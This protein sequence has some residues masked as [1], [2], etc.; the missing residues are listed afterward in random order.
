MSVNS[1]GNYYTGTGGTGTLMHAGESITTTQTLYIY[2]I[3][4]TTPAC[5]VENYFTV[6]FTPRVD[7][8]NPVIACENYVLP[9]LTNGDYYTQPGGTGTMLHAG[10]IISTN[11][12]IYIY[13]KSINRNGDCFDESN[14]TVT[15]VNKPVLVTIPSNAITIC[16]LD[17]NND[18]FTNFDLTTLSPG[19][20]AGQS[21]S[22]YQVTYYGSLN[23]ANTQSNP[24]TNTNL[25]TYII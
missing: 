2:A 17:S 10:D 1:V 3:S 16:D 12:T 13:Y 11:Q 21:S 14:F 9:T 6:S 20:I 24:I 25:K 22:N 7:T 4:N 15:I 19:I 23:D 8:I 5:P 18:G